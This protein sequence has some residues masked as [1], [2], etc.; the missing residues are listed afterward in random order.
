MNIYDIA[1]KAGVSIATVSRVINGTGSVS[2]RTKEKVTAVMQEMGYTP[3]V[4]ARGLMGNSMKTIGVMTIDVRDLYY[5]NSIHII[6]LEARARG[7]DVI[8]CNTGDDIEEK[9]KYLKFLLQKKVDGII[10][11]G[12]AF[13]EKNGNNHIIEAAES[14]PVVM[15]NGFVESENVYSA[16]CDDG[17]G[18]YAMVEYLWSKGHRDILYIYDVET[19]SGVEKIKGFKRA[20]A[21]KV[22]GRLED[23]IFRTTKGIEGG[24]SAMDGIL[25]M[26]KNFTAV[27]ASEDIIAVGIIKRLAMQGIRIPEDVAVTGFNNSIYSNCTTPE[28]TSV[29][30]KVEAVSSGAV[31][32]LVDALEGKKTVSRLV[33]KPELIIR[34]TT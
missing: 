3:N 14:V 29:D 33:I 4:F 11:I 13:K 16:G 7:Y 30:S 20:I 27:V 26:K 8:L 19:F 9:S 2:G 32:L 23:S 21:E 1:K 12:S 5:A 24:Y 34:Q 25:N 28:L 17:R 15:V 31:K 10:L 18:I 22:T 6:E